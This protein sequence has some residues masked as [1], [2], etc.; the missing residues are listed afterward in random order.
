MPNST[1]PTKAELHP[2]NKHRDRYDF[3][4]LIGT[5]PP[6]APFV[7]M[8][9]H[10]EQSI[11]FASP[12]AVRA[13]N[14]A[15]LAH[16]YKIDF[17]DIP[18]HFLCPP[19]PGRADYVHYLADILAESNAGQVPRGNAVKCLDIGI[20]A[21]CVYPIIGRQEYGWSFVGADIDAVAIKSA[22]NIINFNPSLKGGITCRLQYLP[23]QY[24]EGIIKP[25]EYFDLSICN[26]PFHANAQAAKESNARKVSNLSGQKVKTGILN[27]GGQQN[28][29]CCEGGEAQF[30]WQMIKE[31]QQ[32]GQ[33]VGWFSSLVSKKENLV[34][35]SRALTLAKVLDQKVV[36]MKQGNKISRFVAWTFMSDE[37]RRPASIMPQK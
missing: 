1:L 33:N 22:M 5:F 34:G 10:K 7:G 13:L 37:E 14:K 36:E 8:G 12:E 35:I 2:R 11:E 20:G 32:F 23:N 27:F 16:F 24:F 15:V 25:K 9:Q 26:P 31:S 3:E 21:N 29:L 19:I 30:I 28:E 17:W 4:Q 6:L 18:A